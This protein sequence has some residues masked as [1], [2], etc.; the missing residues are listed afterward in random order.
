MS[1]SFQGKSVPMH[2]ATSTAAPATAIVSVYDPAMCCLTGVCGPSVDQQLLQV[3]RYLRRFEA[4][5]V[6]VE[7]FNLAQQPEAFV[8]NPRVAGLLQAFGEEALPVT[9]VNNTIAVYGRYASR[10]EILA[11]LAKEMTPVASA[12]Q[13]TSKCGCEPGSECC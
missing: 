9:L 1:R 2:S 8:E 6:N 12:A 10:E 4:E 11:A 7:R 3:A 5:G 13:E